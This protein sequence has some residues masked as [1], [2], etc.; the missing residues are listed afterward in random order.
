MNTRKP[1]RLQL[2]LTVLM[3]VALAGL[4]TGS[5]TSQAYGEERD[6]LKFDHFACYE[7]RE[8][9][10]DKKDDKKD[11]DRVILFNQF[12][13][14]TKVKV[15]NLKLLCAPTAKIHRKDHDD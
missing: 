13:P 15:G 9:E 1:W 2:S 14:G 7:V 5:F 8:E 12:E 10:K 6:K 11:G 3:M 4:G